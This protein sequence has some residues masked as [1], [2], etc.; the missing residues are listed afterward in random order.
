MV[1]E[2]YPMSAITI[3]TYGIH[4]AVLEIQVDRY[5]GTRHWVVVDTFRRSYM[6]WEH[7]LDLQ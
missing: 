7:T 5:I 6:D 1:R 4:N 2:R 3:A